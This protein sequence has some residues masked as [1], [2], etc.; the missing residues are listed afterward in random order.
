MAGGQP[1]A[2]QLYG[3]QQRP[4][5]CRLCST[6]DAQCSRAQGLGDAVGTP[7]PCCWLHCAQDAQWGRMRARGGG[8]GVCAVMDANETAG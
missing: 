4:H 2:P 7:Q 3:T 5:W 6:R 8:G 1:L